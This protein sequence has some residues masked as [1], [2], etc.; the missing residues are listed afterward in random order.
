MKSIRLA[1]CISVFGLTG[2]ASANAI[3][4]NDYSDAAEIDQVMELA[5]EVFRLKLDGI[6]RT[7]SQ[8]NFV[9]I[10]SRDVLMSRRLDSRTYFVHNQRYGK[11]RPAGVFVG[12]DREMIDSGYEL[13]RRL[14]IPTSEID[15]AVVLQE[16]TQVARFDSRTGTVELEEQQAGQKLG[17]FTRRI[18]DIPVFSS[19]LTLGLTED[20]AIGF[21]QLHW[22]KVPEHVLTEAHRLNYKVGRGWHPPE[23]KGAIAESVHAGIVHSSAQGFLMDIYPV[24]RVIYM[25]ED[26]R[27]GRK[28]TLY[29]DRHGNAV[30][31]PREF[32]IPCPDVVEERR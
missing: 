17:K 29:F 28:L 8:Y 31:M 6:E 27:F 11:Y 18:D 21:M 7:G 12:D 13:F 5:R 20:K 26:G 14:G 19:G 25:A 9:G 10:Q 32:E 3:E 4:P 15:E 23:Q 24:I 1:I 22:P 30:P 2:F 16:K